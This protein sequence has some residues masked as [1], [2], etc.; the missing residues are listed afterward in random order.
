ML[1]CGVCQKAFALGDIVRFIQHKVKSCTNK[2]NNYLGCGGEQSN[3]GGSASG[4]ESSEVVRRPAPILN[5]PPPRSPDR[6]STPKRRPRTPPTPPT[7]DPNLLIKQE[8][9]DS[10]TPPHSSPDEG[11]CKKLRTDAQSNTTNSGKSK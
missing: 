6:C 1:T 10:S 9:V 7:P 5:P 3:G 8:H 4:G 11:P 2:E